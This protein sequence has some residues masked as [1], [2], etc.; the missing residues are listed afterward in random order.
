M[1]E[2]ILFAVI[3]FFVLGSAASSGTYLIGQTAISIF[4]GVG[5]LTLCI[6][7]MMSFLLV[8]RFLNQSIINGCGENEKAGN[9]IFIL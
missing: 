8:I 1:K 7:G 2:R 3:L 9:P 6:I 4:H 5:M